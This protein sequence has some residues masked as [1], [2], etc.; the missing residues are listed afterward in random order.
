VK[1]DVTNLQKSYHHHPVL[2]LEKSTF[3]TYSIEGL[4]GP[5]GAGK[6]TL[7]GLL[8]RRI[9]ATS[10]RINFELDDTR[11]DLTGLRS[12]Q[13]AQLGLVKTN[14]RIQGFESLSIRESLRLAAT[15]PEQ[16]SFTAVFK[17][18]DTSEEIET[19]IEAEIDSYLNTF[20]FSEPD[21][22]ARS[23]GEKKLLDILRCL[24]FKPK[25]LLMDEPTAG[26]P[27]DVTELVKEEIKKQTKETDLKVVIVE[28]DLDLIWSLCDYVHFLSDGEMLFQ[29]TP[30]DVKS[31]RVVAE[32]YLGI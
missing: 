25:M 11:H 16:E 29:G 30:D 8:T 13:V 19:E 10:G 6:S 9:S 5:N 28:H 20:T 24:I 15:P 12:Y 31:N 4:I 21:G 2:N 27:Q 14:Q 7:M 32:K 18:K 26:L 22:F 17:K 1:L 23:A 3:G